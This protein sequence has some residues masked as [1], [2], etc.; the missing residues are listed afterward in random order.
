[1]RKFLKILVSIICIFALC[2]P[3]VFADVDDVMFDLESLGVLEDISKPSDVNGY[4]TRAEFAQLVVN[5]MGYNDVADTMR[6]KGYFSDIS[7]TPYVGAINLLYELKILS[8]TGVGTF[9]PDANITYG[10]V[11]KIMVNVLGYSNIVNGNDLNA[12]FYQAGALGIYK[13][14]LQKGQYVTYRDVYVIVNNSLNVDLMTENFGMFGTGSYEVVE[15]KTLKSYLQTVQHYKLTKYSG[16]VTADRFTYFHKEIGK[17]KTDII[18]IGG[19][20]LKCNFVVPQGYVGMAV[21]YYVEQSNDGNMVVASIRPSSKNKVSEF[22]AED[23]ISAS[24]GVLKYNHADK[25][26]KLKYDETTKVIFNNRRELKFTPS[27]ISNYKNGTV[28][29]IDNNEDEIID[30]VYIYEY[31]DAVVERIYGETKQLYLANNQTIDGKRYISL[32]DEELIVNIVNAEGKRMTFDE[33]SADNVVSV[34]LSNDK[35]IITVVV[36]DKKVTGTVTIIDGDYITIG[37]DVFECPENLNIEVGMHLDAY[38]NFMGEIVCVE[39]TVSYDNYAYVM[40]S[41]VP[42]NTLGSVKVALLVPGHINETSKDSIADDGSSSTSKKLF[43]RNEGK[44]I[45]NLA[46]IVSV[47]GERCKAGRASELIVNQVVSYTLNAKNEISKVDIIKP[48]DEDTYKT[49]NENGKVFSLGSTYG[50]GIDDSKTM[51][52]CVPTDIAGSTDDDLL[53]PVMLLNSTEYK[54]KA[55]DVDEV[56][57]IAGLV[58]VTEEMKAGLPGNVTASSDVAIVKK[59]TKKITND[60]E[61]LV[62]NLLTKE[63]EKNY[64]VSNLIP[65]LNSFSAISSGDLISYSLIDG[66][67]EVNGFSIIQYANG[68]KGNFLLNA[69]QNNEVCLGKVVDFKYNYV[70]QQ[71][72]RWTDNVTVDYGGLTTTYEV[73]MTGTPPIY[74]LEGNDVIEK[75]SF[76]D[77]QIGDKIFVAANVGNVRAIV[78]RR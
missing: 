39:E 53:V 30:V 10:Q 72:N 13:D 7:A 52:I 45:Y 77:I 70:S 54:I 23:F 56:S 32:D 51:S 27:N 28:R 71:K 59:I 17:N 4:M 49:Y 69:F 76:D 50:F 1:M 46:E 20:V 26:V 6:D 48:Y 55:Y 60:E 36:S 24:A 22:D 5:A 16:V 78:I 9:S 15:G 58:V 29:V 65:N 21:D 62:I 31:K 42:V 43:F 67:D 66:K 35:K 34:A 61:R 75:L 19:K 44:V 18:E 64:F 14:T 2:I 41:S 25:S 57:S 8:G 37:T 11:G 33:I 47:D 38:I 3:S 40:K 74:L 63:G 12:Y 68:Y 73:F